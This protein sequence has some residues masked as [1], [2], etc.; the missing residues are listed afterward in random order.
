MY[1]VGTERR[2]L[3]QAVF[4]GGQLEAQFFVNFCSKKFVIFYC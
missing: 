1:K 2:P 4:A 3:N